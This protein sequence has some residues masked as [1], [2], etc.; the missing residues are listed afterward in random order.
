MNAFARNVPNLIDLTGKRFG[1]WLVIAYAGRSHWLCICRCNTCTIVDGANLRRGTSNSC[2]CLSRERAKA[3]ATKH[4]MYGTPEYCS[5]QHMKQ[6][7]LNPRHPRFESYGGRG[8][9]PYE[10]WLSFIPYFADTGT[11]PP[12][13]SLDRIDVNDGY[14]PSNWRWAD[15]KQQAQN[16][17]PQRKRRSK[18]HEIQEFALRMRGPQ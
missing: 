6:R 9:L 12:G 7:C 17:R 3:R 1:R 10:D 16:R 5:W 2:G 14:T 18:L 11:R 8:I 13:C 15:A 4:G